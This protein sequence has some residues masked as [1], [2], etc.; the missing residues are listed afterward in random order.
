MKTRRRQV[1]ERKRANRIRN[2]FR[3]PRTAFIYA[4][5]RRWKARWTL[6]AVITHEPALAA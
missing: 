6:A 1:Y 5:G 2:A 3:A 4:H